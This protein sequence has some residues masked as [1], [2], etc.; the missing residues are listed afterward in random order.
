[1]SKVPIVNLSI[2]NTGYLKIGNAELNETELTRILGLT[3]SSET[4]ENGATGADGPV[5]PAG[6]TGTGGPAGPPGVTGVAGPAGTA[7]AAGPTG[8]AGISTTPGPVGPVGPTGVGIPGP[9]GTKGEIGTPFVIFESYTD[10]TTFLNALPNESNIGKFALVIEE[11]PNHGKLYIY[12]GTGGCGNVGSTGQWQYV[13]DI[14]PLPITG[15]TGPD[16]V[17]NIAGPIGS[18]GI[19]GDRGHTGPA[20]PAGVR[21]QDGNDGQ[22]GATGPQAGIFN[23]FR[24]YNT[25][26]ELENDNN[27]YPYNIGEHAIVVGSENNAGRVYVNVGVGN[28]GTDGYM[29]Q[30]RFIIDITPAVIPGPAGGAGPTGLPGQD[31]QPG[32]AG[33]IGQDGQDGQDGT[34]GPTGADGLRGH[35]GEKGDD[36]QNGLDGP[37]GLD[38]PQ[39]VTGPPTELFNYVAYFTYADPVDM[40]GSEY[41]VGDYALY[42]GNANY[43]GAIYRFVDVGNDGDAGQ[44]NSWKLVSQI[45]QGSRGEQ[46]PTGADG[47]VFKV[48]EYYASESAL[49]T[50][51]GISDT[52]TNEHAIV[53]GQTGE[54]NYGKLYVYLGNG[55]G[56]TGDSGQWK[57][58][59][60]LSPDVIAGQDGSAG[61]AGPA[62]SIGPTG[63]AGNEGSSSI[64]YMTNSIYNSNSTEI[65]DKLYI[66]YGQLNGGSDT[67]YYM[68]KVKEPETT[69]SYRWR[70]TATNPIT[71]ND[72]FTIFDDWAI[73]P[74]VP[75][76]QSYTSS[77]ATYSEG[78]QNISNSP[79]ATSSPTGYVISPATLTANTGLTFNT[80]TGIISG[81]VGQTKAGQYTY[82]ITASNNNGSGT[83]YSITINI[84]DDAVNPIITYSIGGNSSASK[85][86]VLYSLD[87]AETINLYSNVDSTWTV[88]PVF[89]SFI[90]FNDTNVSST[91]NIIITPQTGQTL[92]NATYTITATNTDN[93]SDTIIFDISI[94]TAL[95]VI[96]GYDSVTN[97][98][99]DLYQGTS[100]SLN[101]IGNYLTGANN[102]FT[103]DRPTELTNE[104]GLTF[105]TSTGNISG[106]AIDTNGVEYTYIV[107]HTSDEGTGNDF[108]IKITV[109][110][111]TP[112]PTIVYDP[113]SYTGTVDTA[114]TITPS[115]SSNI[116]AC[117]SSPTIPSG[118]TLNNDGTITGT[119]TVASVTTAYT[120]TASNSDTPADTVDFT[121][122]I[123]IEVAAVAAPNISYS[124]SP[125]TYTDGDPVTITSSNSGDAATWSISPSLGNSLSLDTNTGSITA[126]NSSGTLPATSYTITATNSGG[127][128]TATINITIEAVVVIYNGISSVTYIPSDYDTSMINGQVYFER[129]GNADHFVIKLPDHNNTS[130]SAYYYR[131]PTDSPTAITGFAVNNTETTTVAAMPSNYVSG[132]ASIYELTSTPDQP[133][134]QLY[135]GTMNLTIDG[136]VVN[137][138]YLYVRVPD[139]ASW[140]PNSH[141]VDSGVDYNI[142]SGYNKYRIVYLDALVS[143]T[144]STPIDFTYSYT[145]STNTIPP[146]PSNYASDTN[147]NEGQLFIG[148]IN[149]GDTT[150]IKIFIKL[151]DGFYY[152]PLNPQG[153]Q[154]FSSSGDY[155][156]DVFWKYPRT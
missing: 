143:V 124:G 116:T 99:V 49:L 145:T 138:K 66:A 27:G 81:T 36:G 154:S 37:T 41:N 92:A 67:V 150:G 146:L 69:S 119:P 63:A 53:S 118:L 84:N 65:N 44:N 123:T 32:S 152:T 51:T 140:D 91:K 13:T 31:G 34:V 43:P 115:A 48:F 61:P 131:N 18:T 122:N 22:V 126:T 12:K 46:G 101:P 39:G 130:N 103:I 95:P 57:F 58:V 26:Y 71:D 86:R 64:D 129:S 35:T 139:S 72:T 77:P 128:D 105:N 6:P 149:S 75:T 28:G 108:T 156:S 106:T 137:N 19:Q 88:S 132:L 93:E 10:N 56:S 98:E 141:T 15:P 94:N 4:V 155:N 25:V 121:I 135:V 54:S 147:I 70:Y 74:P 109:L 148:Y 40:P 78:E 111:N 55:N 14:S 90:T 38:G 102:S 50:A 5:G 45:G 29:D 85:T 80:T 120:I 76:I 3:G 151:S 107:S 11:G 47:K 17:S 142:F 62:G 153:D 23:I 42:Q 30:W 82:N 136:V 79:I 20:G 21:G 100:Y 110:D 9:T 87:S 16:G 104:T 83:A 68:S 134:G 89:P 125:F 97:N 133:V 96:T 127:T 114:F 1:M 60:D 59:F 144:N 7:G 52:H 113:I 2:A 73:G 8:P 117:T 33:T 112:N 24:Y